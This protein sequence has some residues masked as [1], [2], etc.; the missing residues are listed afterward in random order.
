MIVFDHSKIKKS[1][2]L[3]GTFSKQIGQLYNISVA[4]IVCVLSYAHQGNKLKRL[5]L[6]LLP[7]GRDAFISLCLSILRSEARFGNIQPDGEKLMISMG[8]RW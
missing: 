6:N 4:K 8:A 1:L 7:R 2:V 5:L 3:K